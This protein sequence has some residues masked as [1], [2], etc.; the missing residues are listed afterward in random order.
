MH[1]NPLAADQQLPSLFFFY[2]PFL[3]RGSI[4]FFISTLAAFYL[5]PVLEKHLNP[6]DY[7]QFLKTRLLLPVGVGYISFTE[8]TRLVTQLP[9]HWAQRL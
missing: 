3:S 5:V 4:H 9:G 8:G 1:T 2:L 6:I 7:S